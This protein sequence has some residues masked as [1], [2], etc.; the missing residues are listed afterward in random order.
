V[1]DF[2]DAT[3]W[4]LAKEVTHLIVAEEC[5]LQ[6]FAKVEPE[7]VLPKLRQYDTQVVG[8]TLGAKGFFYDAGQGIKHTPAFPVNAVDTTGAG[9]IFHGAYTFALAAGASPETC[10]VLASA[11][12]AL[13]CQGFGRSYLP[14]LEQ[15]L[16]FLA[17]RGVDVHALGL[18]SI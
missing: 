16:N 9:D 7:V 17:D 5:V 3:N 8:L 14:T 2:G 10:A 18:D 6:L 4:Y 15:T 13:S 11:V 12:A 1:A